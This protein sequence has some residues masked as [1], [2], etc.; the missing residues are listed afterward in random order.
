[1]SGQALPLLGNDYAVGIKGKKGKGEIHCIDRIDQPLCR[2]ALHD[3][4]ADVHAR[5]NFAL[6]QC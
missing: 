6:V 1:M 4:V 2:L 5:C 3:D